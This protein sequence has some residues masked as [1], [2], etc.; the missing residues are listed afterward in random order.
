MVY[1]PTVLVKFHKHSNPKE[2]KDMKSRNFS[3]E[4]SNH[5]CFS[6]LRWV[7]E[8][9]K[10]NI[11]DCGKLFWISISTAGFLFFLAIFLW[12]QRNL[13]WSLRKVLAPVVR[14]LYSYAPTLS[15]Q[16]LFQFI[17]SR[18]LDDIRVDR[19][20]LHYHISGNF[21]VAA[22][23]PIGVP[24]PAIVATLRRLHECRIYLSSFI[25]SVWSM[26]LSAML[27]WRQ[28]HR[29]QWCNLP[30]QVPWTIFWR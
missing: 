6:Y 15:A 17:Y 11:H 23:V 19:T 9:I 12:F 3:Q 20:L 30:V 16:I 27:E 18:C 21:I 29:S 24:A 5:G 1:T 2:R 26:W 28:F 10:K 13:L 14:I 8:W 25:N 22:S 4:L 7:F